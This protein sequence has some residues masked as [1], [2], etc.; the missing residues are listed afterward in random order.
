M[1]LCEDLGA[2]AVLFCRSPAVPVSLRFSILH[3]LNHSLSVDTYLAVIS[4]LT[5][6]HQWFIS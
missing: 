5:S 4:A 1:D 2:A 3:L 6:F